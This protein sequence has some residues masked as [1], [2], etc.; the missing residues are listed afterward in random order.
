MVTVD[1]TNRW[2]RDAALAGA[3]HGT[4]VLAEEQLAGRGR[5]DRSW[6]APPRSAVLCSMLFRCGLGADDAYLAPAVVGLAALGA[7]QSCCGIQASLKWP[8]DV[9]VRGRKLGG[10]LSELIGGPGVLV[11]GIGLNV[12]WPPGWPPPGPLASLASSATT[13]ERESGRAVRR[14][15][16]ERALLEEVASRAG[17]LESRPGRARIAA[18]YRA[19]CSTLGRKVR[20][21]LDRETLEGLA[22]DLEA[23]GRL[24]LE[25][26]GGR[27]RRLNV[28]DVVHLR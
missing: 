8:N 22:V 12:G 24:V 5:R 17:D 14:D 19:A 13:L 6:S 28:G 25:L 7:A 27:R 23:D 3:P 18:Q 26:P 2:L 16:V 10:I 11:V 20:V 21:E 9:L 1:S 4:S 15:L